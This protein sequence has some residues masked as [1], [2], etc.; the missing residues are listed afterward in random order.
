MPVRVQAEDFDVSAELARLRA[1]DARV[2]AVAAFI[3]TVRDGDEVALFP[4]VTGG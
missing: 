1:G 2:G 3:G 4:P